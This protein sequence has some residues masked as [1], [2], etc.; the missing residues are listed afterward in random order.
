MACC[1]QSHKGLPGTQANTCA[2]RASIIV[3]ETRTL[4]A[5][6][7]CKLLVYVDYIEHVI[8]RRHTAYKQKRKVDLNELQEPDCKR[9]ENRLKCSFPFAGSALRPSDEYVAHGV[10]VDSNF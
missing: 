7:Q 3:P 9:L 1:A 8:S 5:P 2:L 6:M 4:R 10:Y